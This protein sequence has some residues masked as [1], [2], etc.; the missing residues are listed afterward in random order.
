MLPV[1]L[2]MGPFLRLHKLLRTEWRFICSG[3]FSR[4]PVWAIHTASTLP[5]LYFALVLAGMQWWEY[6]LY[7]VYPGMM[8][9]QPSLVMGFS[10]LG[11]C[12]VMTTLS[13]GVMFIAAQ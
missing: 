5:L 10:M 8:L 3:D 9:G 1:R 12:A 13:A 4:L 2:I 6:L 11:G 7:F